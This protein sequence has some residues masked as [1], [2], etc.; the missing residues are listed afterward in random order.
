MTFLSPFALA[1]AAAAAIPLLIHLWRRRIGARVDFPAVRYLARA[2]R[3]HSRKLRLRNLLLMVLRLAIVLLLAVAAARPVGRVGGGGHAPTAIA[4]VLD[5][6]LSTGVIA[7]G[8]SVFDALTD[9]A[10]ATI[11]RATATDRVWLVTA[12]GRIAG[13]SAPSLLADAGRLTTL[14]GAGDLASALAAAACLVASSGLVE[15]QIVVVSDGQ[16]TTWRALA[17]LRTESRVLIHVPSAAPPANRAVVAASAVPQRWT[18]HGSVVARIATAG[19]SVS[20]RVTLSAGGAPRTLAR[21]GAVPG[22]GSLAD[23]S[24]AASPA[25]RGWVAGTVEIEP[26]EL[27]ADDVRHFALWIGGAPAVQAEAGAGPFVASAV[28]ALVQ[29]GRAATGPGVAIV[30]ADAATRLPALI[31]A[32]ADPVRLGAA[33]RVLARLG[34]PWR[35]GVPVTGGETPVRGDRLDGVTVVRRYALER[36]GT[37]PSDTLARAG[38]APWIVAGEGWVLV[39]SPLDPSA[40]SLPVRAAFV[41]LLGELLGQRLAGAEGGTIYAAPGDSVPRP[42][43]ATARDDGAAAPTP[44]SGPTMIVPQRAGTFFLLDRDRRAGALVVNAGPDE[45]D[46]TRLD[47]EALAARA[48]GASVRVEH[49]PTRVADRAFAASGRRP[50]AVPVLATVLLL[51]T[52]EAVVTRARRLL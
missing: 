46:L 19:D 51:L 52:T 3:E 38:G 8:R 21:G 12:D 20:W 48:R 33:N 39:A 18:P 2:E 44:L 32:P 4:I 37:A 16:A 22:S 29:A 42:S 13:G 5:N 34:I 30:S 43:W 15:R 50:L 23:V 11:A 36:Q 14:A 26:D 10:R 25:E 6:S 27:R 9:V 24:V 49:D 17:P 1:L 7:G 35:F 41:P 40:T 45:S 28:A 47:D 31:L